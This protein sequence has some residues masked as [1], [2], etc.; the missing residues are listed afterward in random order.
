V[1]LSVFTR[2]RRPD[3]ALP[4]GFG[5]E[6][7]GPGVVASDAR[8]VADHDETSYWVMPMDDG[9]SVM[10]VGL[11]ERGA[12]GGIATFASLAEQ[13]AAATVE[14]RRGLWRYAILVADGFT[15]VRVGVAESPVVDNFA[16]VDVGEHERFIWL[17][18]VGGTQHV[19]LGPSDWDGFERGEG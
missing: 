2:L 10:F 6:A 15:S 16:I 9:S 12:S 3:D 4:G 18:G 19:D 8:H 14:L 7:F 1:T 11:E 13:G 5:A 17:E